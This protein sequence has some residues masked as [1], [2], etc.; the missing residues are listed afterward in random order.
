MST[1]EWKHEEIPVADGP[2]IGVYT[3]M[4]EEECDVC[5]A[6]STGMVHSGMFDGVNDVHKVLCG[7]CK[8]KLF[9]LM[10][11]QKLGIEEALAHMSE[12]FQHA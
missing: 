10:H 5:H 3:W 4:K 6:I 9:G 12:P 11:E 8:T 7:P 1:D 2:P